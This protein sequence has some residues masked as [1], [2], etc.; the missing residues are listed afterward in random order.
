ML[1]N[2]D[3]TFTVTVQSGDDTF[4]SE[5]QCTKA[6]IVLL[7]SSIASFNYSG[8]Q[9]NPLLAIQNVEGVTL[10]NDVKVGD[11]WS[12]TLTVSGGNVEGTIETTYNAVGHETVNVPAGTFNALK[13][14]QNGS[15]QM[16]GHTSK[17]HAFFWYAQNVGVIKSVI[18]GVVSS[19]LLAYN[20]P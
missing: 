4:I 20:F 13:V 2:G 6:G 18:D 10:P 15:I 9:G 12:Q 8:E 3:N 7:D 16:A 19:E 14:E 17:S 1:V 5:G 11:D